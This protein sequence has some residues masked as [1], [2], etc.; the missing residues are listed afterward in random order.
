MDLGAGQADFGAADDREH[1]PGGDSVPGHDADLHQ[2]SVRGGPDVDVPC[3]VVLDST[4]HD[5]DVL[6]RMSP[7]RLHADD[8]ARRVFRHPRRPRP[9]SPDLGPSSSARILA[10]PLP[11]RQMRPRDGHPAQQE[12]YDCYDQFR[13][14]M[15]CALQ[16]AT[17][18]KGATCRKP[19]RKRGTGS[20]KR[21]QA[22]P[23]MGW[24]DRLRLGDRPSGR[25]LQDWTCGRHHRQAGGSCRHAEKAVSTA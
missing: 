1:L 14:F 22:R 5:M 4:R 12:E 21:Q 18:R 24:R 10:T 16:R 8:P 15:T 7:G 13:I 3:V 17:S 25:R 2:D 9:G 6:Q 23:T 20:A 19:G 11:S